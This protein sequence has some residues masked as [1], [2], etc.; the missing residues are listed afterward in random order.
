MK[1]YSV[2]ALFVIVA[3]IFVAGPL[4]GE[5]P[6]APAQVDVDTIIKKVD[7][8]Y[9]ANTSQ[10]EMEMTITTPNWER[11]MRMKMWTEGMKKTF[12]TILSPKKD[13]GI[14]T[15]RMDQ[16]MWNFFPKINK[17]MKIPPSMMMGSWMGS[18]FTNDD[19]VKESTM[20]DDYT[21]TLIT[22]ANAEAD[23]YYIQLVPKTNTASVWGKI[24]VTV[25]R[26]TYMPVTQEYYDEKG[27]KMRIMYFKEVKE[28]GGRTIPTVMELV[29]LNKE[30]H[31]TLIKY[32][33]A[34]F[35]K[36]LGNDIFTLQNLQQTR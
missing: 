16:E 2:C 29:P 8:L 7:E 4:W 13:M 5:E 11:T 30:N 1:L 27:T 15:L 26:D 31:K 34:E 6:K 18:D 9:R 24:I 36:P 3:A 25:L 21:S 14:S 33:S 32:I 20:I 28:M 22:P 12:I 17:V 35:D 10:G 19:L 23:K